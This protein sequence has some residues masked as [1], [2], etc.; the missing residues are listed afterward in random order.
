M[1]SSQAA[2]ITEYA[3]AVQPI[4]V[5][6]QQQIQTLKTQHDEFISS[7]KQSQS[8]TVA[9]LAT[10]AEPEKAVAM[11]TQAGEHTH[12]WTHT[13]GQTQMY[14]VCACVC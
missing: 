7:L 4:Q 1:L 2:L 12:T 9:Q 6:F 10:S 13:D 5:A 11:T 14:S 3:A 8:A